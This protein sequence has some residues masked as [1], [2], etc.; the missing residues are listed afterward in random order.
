METL[1]SEDFC[2]ITWLTC[3]IFVFV[4]L[5]VLKSLNT[6]FTEMELV[7][8]A[9]LGMLKFVEAVMSYCDVVREVKPKREKVQCVN[10]ASEDDE[11]WCSSEK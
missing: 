11:T 8:R 7:S 4:H 1:F 9:G 6:T 10:S 5:A 2:T 3:N